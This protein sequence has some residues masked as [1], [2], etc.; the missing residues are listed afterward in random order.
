MKC[1][2]ILLVIAL[3]CIPGCVRG[4]GRNAKQA[5]SM[6]AEALYREGLQLQQA[7]DPT[8]AEQ[9]LVS[10]LR[11]GHDRAVVVKAL[12]IT[13]IA[14]GRLRSA[15]SYA[16]PY[17]ADHPNQLSLRM[18]VA[19]LHLALENAA[20]AQHELDF[21]LRAAETTPEAHYMMALLMLKQGS[22]PAA[23]EQHFRRY[24]EL[25]PNG[26][27]ADEARAARETALLPQ[28]RTVLKSLEAAR[29][30]R[31]A[32]KTEVPVML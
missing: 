16:E 19:S 3:L 30:G 29:P 21:V 18:L 12:M 32:L 1:R 17:L 31:G 4:A 24:L 15:L 6:P 8:R 22:P 26:R 25:A 9:Y 27:H 13:C 20:R 5:D 14:A 28:P 10:A 7:G 11:A 2:E 23:A